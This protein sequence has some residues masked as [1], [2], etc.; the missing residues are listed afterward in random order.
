MVV[1]KVVEATDDKH[2]RQQGIGLLGEMTGATRK[3]G[4]ALAE[5]GMQS[6]DESGVDDA[7]PWL[8]CRSWRII[9]SL[10]CTIRRWIVNAWFE[11]CLTTWTSAMSGQAMRRGRPPLPF[12]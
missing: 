3:P 2:T 8:R 10:P 1:A 7:P 9:V 6:F 4:K 11:R 12:S 5:G